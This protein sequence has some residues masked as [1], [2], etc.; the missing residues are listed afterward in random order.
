MK[1]RPYIL[2]TSKEGTK[3]L[4]SNREVTLFCPECGEQYDIK[5]S[6]MITCWQ[7]RIPCPVTIISTYHCDCQCGYSVNLIPVD[8]DIAYCVRALHMHGYH[9]NREYSSGIELD[10]VEHITV[11]IQFDTV[12]GIRWPLPS[13][14]SQ[15]GGVIYSTS[16][17]RAA[18][19]QLEQWIKEN[20]IDEEISWWMHI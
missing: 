6:G 11:F 7:E 2:S 20:R 10:D 3:S 4:I 16:D 17:R 5:T 19:S 1:H 13:M 14:W 15:K 9:V 18:V 12:Y 8:A